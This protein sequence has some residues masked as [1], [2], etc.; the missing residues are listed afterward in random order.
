MRNKFYVTMTDS[1]MSGW[2]KAQ[3]KKNKFI[4][5]CD[6]YEQAAIIERNAHKRGEMKYINIC[7]NRPRYGQNV[8][9]S[10]RD[11]SDLG[12]IWTSEV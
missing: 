5:V 2:G 11:F 3:G 4:V 6:T 8:V 7:L 1:F 9:E 12:D 10:W